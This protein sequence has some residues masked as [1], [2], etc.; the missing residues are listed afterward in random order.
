MAAAR[1]GYGLAAATVLAGWWLRRRAVQY[2]GAPPGA[3]QGAAPGAPPAAPRAPSPVAPASLDS[4]A[5]VA[6][7]DQ[8]IPGMSLAIVREGAVLLERGYGRAEGGSEAAGARTR[9][10]IAS[11]TK[12]FTAA[13]VLRLAERGA[14]DLDEP[15]THF[16]EG[17]P[18]AYQEVTLRRLLNHTAGVPN[19]TEVFRRF[20]R[21]LTPTQVV[22]SLA[23]RPLLFKPGS[24]FRYSNSGYY[25]LGRVIEHT[26]GQS[27]GDYLRSEFWLPLGMNDT[28]YCGRGS[29]PQG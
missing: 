5:R 16:V 11:V 28:D 27:F 19:F 15:V 13:A 12:Q 24:G 10:Q 9:Y 18:P 6:M 26:T 4:I 8:S 22:D 2:D 1:I 7:A 21:P 23:A 20:R 3:A 14:L 25:L 29:L 17:L